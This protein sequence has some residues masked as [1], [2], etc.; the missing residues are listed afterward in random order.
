MTEAMK[1]LFNHSFFDPYDHSPLTT[2]PTTTLSGQVV[3]SQG[4]GGSIEWG[5]V[6]GY[7][8]LGIALLVLSVVLI[9]QSPHLAERAWEGFL[10]VVGRIRVML[11]R[12]DGQPDEEQYE[13]PDSPPVLPPARPLPLNRT[14]SDRLASLERVCRSTSV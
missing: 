6:V 13:L 10:H 12:G 7:S 8:V 1:G 11:A 14:D 3:E 9:K 2:G 5:H 4:G